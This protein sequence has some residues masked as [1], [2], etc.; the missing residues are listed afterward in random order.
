M[1]TSLNKIQAIEN[2]ITGAIAP[3][4]RILFE[5]NQLLDPALADEVKLQR[6]TYDIITAYNRALLKDEL[7]CL[8]HKVMNDP[9]KKSFADLIRS[10][11]KQQ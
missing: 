5:A 10:I 1:R 11:F 9:S 8:H 7:N 4:E 2:F 3:S 6:N